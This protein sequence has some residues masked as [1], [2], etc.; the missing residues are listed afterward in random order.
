MA[1][2]LHLTLVFLGECDEKQ[3]SAARCAMDA[4]VFEPFEFTLGRVG[5][6]KRDGGDV[7]W[8]AGEPP[9]ALLELQRGLTD[10]LIRDGFRL[11]R[12]KYSPHITLGRKVVTDAVP[13]QVEPFG[14]TVRSIEL[15]KSERIDGK[16]TYTPIYVKN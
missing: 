12:R 2:N 5:R 11:D 1:E 7:W 15:M 14:E 3:A 13:W 9:A 16:L 6:F 10:R 4:V 8:V